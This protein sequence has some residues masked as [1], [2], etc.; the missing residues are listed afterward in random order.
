MNLARDIPIGRSA[1]DSLMI[2]IAWKKISRQMSLFL[3]EGF[4]GALAARHLQSWY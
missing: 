4:S 1:M 2:I 3:E